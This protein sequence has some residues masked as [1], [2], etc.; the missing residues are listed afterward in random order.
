MYHFIAVHL[1]AWPLNKSEA[2]GDLA[3]ML[4]SRNLHKK[5]GEV[6]IKTR[7]PS[8]SLL[9]KGQATKRTHVKWPIHQII[10]SNYDQINVC[11]RH[12]RGFVC[13]LSRDFKNSVNNLFLSSLPSSI[14]I[15]LY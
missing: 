4:I 2:G 1:V 13:S 6:H 3:L 10:V 8:P 14:T 11:K 15:S 5:S 7:S 9:Y 12:H